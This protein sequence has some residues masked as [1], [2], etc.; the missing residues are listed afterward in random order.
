MRLRILETA[1]PGPQDGFVSDMRRIL[2][3][4]PAF[5]GEPLMALLQLVLRESLSEWSVGE[6]ELIAAFVAGQSRCPF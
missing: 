6:R 1:P 5:A 2:G 3:H 4:R